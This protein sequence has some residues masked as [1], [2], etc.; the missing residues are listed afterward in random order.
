MV[1]FPCD[2]S[3]FF[4]PTRAVIGGRAAQLCVNCR[5]MT[6]LWLFV[7]PLSEQ[8]A[9][10]AWGEDRKWR[11]ANRWTPSARGT[12]IVLLKHLSEYRQLHFKAAGSGDKHCFQ[13]PCKVV[14][15]FPAPVAPTARTGG[16]R[17]W[18]D[19]RHQASDRKRP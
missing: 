19:H 14:P 12:S 2:S 8:M 11:R 6:G 16:P 18:R 9:F 3:P 13:R 7:A 10:A 15:P 17:S 5:Q 4:L 1:R